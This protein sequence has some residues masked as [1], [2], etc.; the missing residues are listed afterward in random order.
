[1]ARHFL[2][3][4]ST[5]HNCRKKNWKKFCKKKLFE[6]SENVVR[7]CLLYFRNSIFGFFLEIGLLAMIRYKTVNFNNPNKIF[8]N[9][10][11]ISFLVNQ[12]F[13][14]FIIDPVIPVGH[15]P[16]FAH[17]WAVTW[18]WVLNELLLCWKITWFWLKNLFYDINDFVRT[19][20]ESSTLIYFLFYWP[21]V[22]T[23][24]NGLKLLNLNRYVAIRRCERLIRS[25]HKSVLILGKNNDGFNDSRPPRT[26]FIPSPAVYPCIGAQS[27]Q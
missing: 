1:M 9:A 14:K 8:D 15:N 27:C 5:I 23:I 24:E 18:T 19:S 21:F 26:D 22:G 3:I 13:L 12:H 6:P 25:F 11:A 17:R 7:E 2:E 20:L 16:G 10:G 4:F